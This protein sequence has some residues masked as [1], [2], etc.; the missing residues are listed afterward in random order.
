MMD[1]NQVSEID[2]E[3][4]EELPRPSPSALP[5]DQ[6]KDSFS[7]HTDMRMRMTVMHE[8][9][10]VD[11]ADTEIY[12][13]S[14]GVDENSFE[15]VDHGRDTIRSETSYQSMAGLRQRNDDTTMQ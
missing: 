5:Q 15:S 1:S 3:D 11:D 7:R 8:Q 6:F 13:G 10:H 9:A 4:L 12:E 14:S 2:D